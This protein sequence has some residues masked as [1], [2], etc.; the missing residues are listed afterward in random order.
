VEIAARLVAWLKARQHDALCELKSPVP[1][2]EPVD[3]ARLGSSHLA[4]IL[5]GDGTLL[6][7][8]SVV[9]D[10]G[11]PILGINLGQLGFLTSSAPHEAEQAVERALAGELALEERLRL[12][13]TLR[14][15]NGEVTEHHACNDVVVNQGALARLIELEAFLDGTRVTHYRAD[16]LIIST[17]TGSTAYNLAAGGPILTPLLDAMVLTPICPHTLTNRPLVVPAAS[18]LEI[19]LASPADHV[20][21]TIDGQWGTHLH[22]DDHVELRRGL[23]PLRLYRPE[24]SHFEV[25]RQKLHWGA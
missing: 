22:T 16:G 21:L 20:M 15:N 11:V 19:R 10:H 9:A 12:R 4:V 23:K 6:H 7:G 8:A 1:G 14:R 24:Q 3:A 25:L 2:A 5:G 17:P 18:R 13:C